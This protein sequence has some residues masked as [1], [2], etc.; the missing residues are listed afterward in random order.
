MVT[1][2]A[3]AATAEVIVVAAVVVVIKDAVAAAVVAVAVQRQSWCY[4]LWG[5]EASWLAQAGC[6]A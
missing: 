4:A 3:E 5:S 2:V 6:S 1:V